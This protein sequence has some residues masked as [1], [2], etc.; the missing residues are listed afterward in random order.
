MGTFLGSAYSVTCRFRVDY[1]N[2]NPPALPVVVDFPVYDLPWQ[3]VSDGCTRG[4]SL[5]INGRQLQLFRATF[6]EG[7]SG[8]KIFFPLRSGVDEGKEDKIP[9]TL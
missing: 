6:P 4:M 8:W 7:Y 1:I 2:V 5:V 3:S 9:F